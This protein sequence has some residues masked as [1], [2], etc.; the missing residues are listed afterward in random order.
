MNGTITIYKTPECPTWMVKSD[1]PQVLAL[2]G[3]DDL[4]TAFGTSIHYTVVKT[5]IEQMNPRA[6]IIVKL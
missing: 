1:D 2:F 5:M 3:T 6:L 4:P